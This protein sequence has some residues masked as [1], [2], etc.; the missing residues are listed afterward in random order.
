MDI[1]IVVENLKRQPQTYATLLGEFIS[2]NT[3]QRIIRRKLTK[4][5]ARGILYRALISMS[6]LL[7]YHPMK[8]YTLFFEQKGLRVAVYYAFE[9]TE[10]PLYVYVKTPYLLS[11]TS[12]RK[13]ND[14]VLDK[15]RLL[16]VA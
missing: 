16:K 15:E 14:I 12:W 11:K 5:C 4:L 6:Q 2:D 9:Y 13:I 3:Q 10:D 1:D 8:T 7:F